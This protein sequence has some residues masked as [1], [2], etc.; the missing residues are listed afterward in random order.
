[1]EPQ[2]KSSYAERANNACKHSGRK[3]DVLT[4][5]NTI[6]VDDDEGDASVIEIEEYDEESDGGVYP[7]IEKEAIKVEDVPENDDQDN[8]PSL[9]EQDIVNPMESLGRGKRVR[10]PRQILIPAMKGKHHNEGV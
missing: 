5:S 3:T 8:P 7:G 1:M 6:G 10:L 2:V 9:A 4:Q